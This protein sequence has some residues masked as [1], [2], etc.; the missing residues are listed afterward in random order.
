MTDAAISR[1]AL[2]A[3]AGAGAAAAAMPTLA[4]AQGA[5]PSIITRPIP[6]SGEPLPVVGIGSAVIFEYEN[7]PARQAERTA[8]IRTLVAG[9]G[10]LI[11]TAPA[12]GNAE[13]RL[14]EIIADLGVRDRLFLATKFASREPRERH[15]ASLKAS[16]ERMRT[17]KFDLMQAWN[18]NDPNFDLGLLREWK[19]QGICRYTG[20]T[21]SFDR[22][23]AAIE[24]VVKREKPDF[25]QINYSLADRDAE[26]RL[27][28]AARDAGCAVLTNLPFGRASM[29]KK[30]AG[31]PLPDWAR[32]ID[33]T[34]W[35]QIFLKFLLS[36]P[37]V[38]AVIPG[39]DKPEYMVDNLKAGQGR[40]P[41]AAMRE[42]IVQHWA[43][44]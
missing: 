12:Y 15:A 13:L 2:L 14:G 8:V 22:D 30:V 19:A 39:T 18:V 27:L 16:Q 24:E 38:T 37:A 42:R 36:H 28:P 5:A 35:A 41:D 31:K 1:R 11:D 17:Q 26:A 32:E 33:A 3:A 21:S 4:V 23:Y 20:I 7:D 43:T 25:F 40:L 6:V 29:F 10:K 34:S 9:G 44:L